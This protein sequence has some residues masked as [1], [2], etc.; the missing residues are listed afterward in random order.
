MLATKV[1]DFKDFLFKYM[2]Q[3]YDKGLA[4]VCAGQAGHK[5]VSFYTSTPLRNWARFMQVSQI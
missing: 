3:I 4:D 1:V 5:S 2:C